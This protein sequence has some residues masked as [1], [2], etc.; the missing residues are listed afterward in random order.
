MSELNLEYRVNIKF[1]VKIDKIATE[2]LIYITTLKNVHVCNNN[3]PSKF[4][5]QPSRVTNIKK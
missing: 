1:N 5:F 3:I 2:I 4:L